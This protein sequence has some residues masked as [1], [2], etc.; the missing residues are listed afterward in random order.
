MPFGSWTLATARWLVVLAMVLIIVPPGKADPLQS[1][2]NWDLEHLAVEYC[3][4]P[5]QRPI[6]SGPDRRIVC[7]DGWIDDGMDLST[8]HDLQYGGLFVV[9]SFGGQAATAMTLSRLLRD[10]HAAVVVYDYCMAA[11]AS[12][13]LISSDQ[14]YVTSGS[15]VAWRVVDDLRTD[16]VSVG[17]AEDGRGKRLRRISCPDTSSEQE[18]KSRAAIRAEQAFYAE[19]AVKPQFEGPP[20]SPYTRRMVRTSTISSESIR[21]SRGRSIH[22]TTSSSRRRSSMRPT[23]PVKTMSMRSPRGTA[24]GKSSMIHER[25][26]RLPSKYP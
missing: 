24:S 18:Q 11:C 22:G 26:Q 14:A 17:D 9:R 5:L 3:R 25:L 8:I 15:I 23:P 16:C 2:A 12:F 19:R 1:E 13:L 7:F 6:A 20:D 21:G 4:G 10:R